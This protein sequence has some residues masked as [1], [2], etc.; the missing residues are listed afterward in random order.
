MD[1]VDRGSRAFG[2]GSDWDE[3]RYQAQERPAFTGRPARSI[4]PQPVLSNVP[5]FRFFRTSFQANAVPF[6][7]T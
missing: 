6:I 4:D 5:V 2:G 7:A 3:R 1:G